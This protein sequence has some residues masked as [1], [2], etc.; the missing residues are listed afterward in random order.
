M[1]VTDFEFLT[2]KMSNVSVLNFENG[3]RFIFMHAISALEMI[4]FGNEISALQVNFLAISE[5]ALVNNFIFMHA[6]E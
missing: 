6:G 1:L 5:F 3:K 2:L 4:L